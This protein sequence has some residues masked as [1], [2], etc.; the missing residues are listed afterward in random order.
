ML[1]IETQEDGGRTI[2]VNFGRIQTSGW[3]TL[4]LKN[5]ILLMLKHQQPRNECM[6][7]LNMA[8]NGWRPSKN[9]IILANLKLVA[10][11]PS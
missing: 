10:E 3:I 8:L 5:Q 2:R 11:C 6:Y 1:T 9:M 4:F 7:G